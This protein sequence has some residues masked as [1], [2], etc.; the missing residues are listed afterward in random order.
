M[1][2]SA[3]LVLALLVPLC[4]AF[5]A[6]PDILQQA[7]SAHKAGNLTKAIQLYKEFLAGHPDAAEIRSN[8][9]AALVQDG[10]L[11]AAIEEYRAALKTIPRNAK[12][13]MNLAL[14]YYKVG[15]LPD[16]IRELRTI[17]EQQ[18]LELPPALLLADCLLQSGKPEQVV[19][20]LTPL[21]EDN[22]DEKSIAY[23]LGIALLK[24]NRTA[25]AQQILDS[26]L[27]QG[28][29]AEGEYL[30]GQVESMRQNGLGAAAHLARAIEINPKLPGVHSLYGQVL[31]SI[32]KL[33]EA[34]EQ[35]RQEL[36]V[37]PYDYT[38][39]TEAAMAAK[40]DGRY[41]EAMRHLGIALQLRPGD[42]GVRLQ[43]ASIRLAQ[44]EADAARQ[45]LEQIVREYP[46]FAE[47]HATLATAY[48][49][50]KRKADGDREREAARKAQDEGAKL[51]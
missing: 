6:S 42:P 28:Q 32:G 51:R 9:G 16:A 48:Y 50:L 25:E 11:A 19:E 21:R 4:S 8:L 35:Y 46:S 17:R 23:L 41:D 49:K 2:N 3:V 30:L 31:W 40:Q 34:R 1:R 47:A 38:A 14:G 45:E 36:K 5:Q 10:Q 15:R 26:V 12:V 7:T 44:G 29:S 33:D 13:R 37:N 20:L 39:N 43:R 27:G 18:P 24:Q 22:P